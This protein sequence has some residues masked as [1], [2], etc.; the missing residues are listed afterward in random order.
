MIVLPNGQR[1]RSLAETGENL[2]FTAFAAAR[3]A[4]A[5]SANLAEWVFFLAG[6]E[7]LP[8]DLSNANL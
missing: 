6:S 3:L 7:A 1:V 2:I 5:L 4:P 8:A